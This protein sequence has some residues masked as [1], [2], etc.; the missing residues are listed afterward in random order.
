MSKQLLA[1]TVLAAGLCASTSAVGCDKEGELQF[2]FSNLK[3]REAFAIFADFAG[4]RPDI[5]AAIVESGPIKFGCTHWRVAAESLARQ[6]HL[7][8]RVAGGVLRVSR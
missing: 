6:Y 5:A 1:F 2:S 8:M 7:R 4:L 3:V